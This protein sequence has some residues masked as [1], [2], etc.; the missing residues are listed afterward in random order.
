MVARF[1]DV[2]AN[3][4]VG[5]AAVFLEGPDEPSGVEV[6]YRDLDPGVSVFRGPTQ[7]GARVFLFPR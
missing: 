3:V 6:W 1:Q 2:S 7:H 4:N 5:K